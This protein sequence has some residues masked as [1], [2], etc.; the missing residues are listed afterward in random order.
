MVD[1]FVRRSVTPALKYYRLHGIG[2]YDYQYSDAELRQ[3]L[4][5]CQGR[6]IY[7]MFNNTYMLEDALRFRQLLGHAL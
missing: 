1:P 3:L 7:C 5:W 4:G 2:G 6:R